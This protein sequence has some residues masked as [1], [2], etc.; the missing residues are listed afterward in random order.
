MKIPYNFMD[1]FYAYFWSRLLTDLH[2][3]LFN[4]RL[5]KNKCLSVDVLHRIRTWGTWRV[6]LLCSGRLW[7]RRKSWHL[8]LTSAKR[9]RRSGGGTAWMPCRNFRRSRMR[10][11]ATAWRRARDP[12]REPRGSSL[13]SSDGCPEGSKVK[14]SMVLKSKRFII[15]CKSLRD[16]NN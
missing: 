12:H 3:Q 6:V 14:S 8:N 10:W 1:D 11:T 2:F 4:N 13:V 7:K 15:R 16:N 5:D 9:W